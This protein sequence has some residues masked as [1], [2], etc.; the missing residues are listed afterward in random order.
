[1]AAHGQ[2][3]SPSDE[4]RR[5]NETKSAKTKRKNRKSNIQQRKIVTPKEFAGSYY[6][7]HGAFGG[8]FGGC[9]SNEKGVSTWDISCSY[10]FGDKLFAFFHIYFTE[11]HHVEISY[12]SAKAF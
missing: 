11:E 1:M 6:Y 2:P 8:T 10:I 3:R 9:E 5:V 4:G 12:V 7:V